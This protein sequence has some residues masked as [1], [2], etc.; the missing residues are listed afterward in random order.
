M[1]DTFTPE[2]SPR[3]ASA[4]EVHLIDDQVVVFETGTDRV[5]CLNPT[6][7]LVFEL[8]D[9][10]RPVAAIV[11]TVR[12]AYKL[13]ENPVDAVNTCLADLRTAGIIR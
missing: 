12:D 8:C 5:H 3:K 6:A 11:D 7:A 1:A 10:S 9:G 4:L 13:S 2:E